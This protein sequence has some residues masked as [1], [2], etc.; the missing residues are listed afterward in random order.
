MGNQNLLLKFDRK[1]FYAANCKRFY[2]ATYQACVYNV[3][4]SIPE[5]KSRSFLLG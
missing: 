5:Y 1:S 4:D 3:C 2:V